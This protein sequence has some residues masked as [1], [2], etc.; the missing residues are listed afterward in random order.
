MNVYDW[1]KT[2]TDQ[3]STYMFLTWMYGKYPRVLVNEAGGMLKAVWE[4]VRSEDKSPGHLKEMLFS[5]L[6]YIPDAD[7]A[8]KQFWNEKQDHIRP[9]YLSNRKENDVVISASPEF[10]VR[11]MAESLGIKHV[12]ATPMNPLSGCIEGLNCKGEEKVRRFLLEYP[13]QIVDE[14]YSDSFADQPMADLAK[15]AYMVSGSGI[16]PWPKK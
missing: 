3:D 12:I 13:G 16:K 7:N 14:F 1:D 15:K 9:W 10:L 11:P 8:V 5:I 6:K 4:L 2:I